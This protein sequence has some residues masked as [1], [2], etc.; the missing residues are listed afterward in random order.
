[1]QR[2][3]ELVEAFPHQLLDSANMITDLRVCMVDH[4]VIIPPDYIATI[5]RRGI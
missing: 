5:V 3:L 4:W 2:P 1:M